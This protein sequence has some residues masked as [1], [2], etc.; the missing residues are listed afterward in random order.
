MTNPS[1]VPV[2]LSEEMINDLLRSLLH[3][4]GSWID[5]G[6][7]CQTLHK[8]GYPPQKLFEETGFQSSQQNLIIV[9]SQVYDSLSQGQGEETLLRYFQGP[10]SDIL[11]ELRILNQDQRLE[12]A[13]LCYEKNLEFDSAKE[14]AKAIQEFSR[15]SHFPDG[16][17]SDAGDVMAYQCW[18]QAR[19]KKDLQERS[20]LI[21]KGL[22]FAHSTTARTALEKLLTDFT[23]VSSRGAPLLPIHRLEAEEELARIVPLAGTFP[24]LS[25]IFLSIPALAVVEP[26]RFVEITTELKALPLP[27]WQSVL[28]AQDPVAILC[29]GEYLPNFPHQQQEEVLVVID[30]AVKD[31][32]VNYYYLIKQGEEL[33]IK[34]WEESP[35]EPILGQVVVIVRPKRIFDENNLLEPWQM[36]D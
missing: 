1:D 7:A 13:R 22:K 6:K 10:K 31:H 18:R 11:Y 27:G 17:T 23:L 32:D 30:R 4:E 15:L 2:P 3:K 29:R 9:A 12:A 20:R 33:G 24:L 26:F 25:H 19:Q 14:V 35:S 28:K 21:A 5:W 8:A 36:D 34:W 16:F